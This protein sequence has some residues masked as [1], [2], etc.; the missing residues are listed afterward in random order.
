MPSVSEMLREKIYVAPK[1]CPEIFEPAD[2][3]KKM[4]LEYDLRNCLNAPV[5]NVVR[6]TGLLT[7]LIGGEKDSKN[8]KTTSR[9]VNDLRNEMSIKL[10]A[11]F[12]R[13]T[14]ET[15][16]FIEI[17][18]KS[19]SSERSER[20]AIFASSIPYTSRHWTSDG[21]KKSTPYMVKKKIIHLTGKQNKERDLTEKE[22]RELY[23]K[24]FYIHKRYSKIYNPHI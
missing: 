16:T 10:L 12:S 7:Q 14:Q 17:V 1:T 19:N 24:I 6:A 23:K 18:A 22:V 8:L 3:L 9:E 4:G 11:N 13:P 21:D 15:P 20:L 2:G 5:F